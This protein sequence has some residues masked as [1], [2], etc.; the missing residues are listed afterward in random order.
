MS[1]SIEDIKAV[2]KGIT[3][4]NDKK[5]YNNILK[6]L[7]QYSQVTDDEGEFEK[8]EPTMRYLTVALFQIFK[9]LFT[10]G[11]LNPSKAANDQENLFFGWCRKNYESFKA[12]LLHFISTLSF[13]NSLVLDSLDV[14]F[15][16]IELESVYYASKEGAPFFPNK[17]LKKLILALFQST[18]DNDVDPT[19]GESIN[20][21]VRE[22]SEKY[23]KKYVDIQ[24]YFQ[25]E[26]SQVCNDESVSL[27][28]IPHEELMSKWLTIM[29]HDNHYSSKDADLDIFVPQPPTAMENEA[30]FKSNFEKN[31]I[32]FLSLSQLTTPQYKTTLL[33]LHKRVIQHF[34]TP[35]KLMDFLTDS[36]NVGG[37][38]SILSLNGLFELMRRY[39][40]EYPNFYTKLY[41]LIDENLMHVKYR[42]RFLRLTDTFLSST[43]LSAN[44]I[45]SFIKKL[46]RLT[47]AA[48]PAA[49]VSV[50]PFVYNLLKKHPNCMIMLHDPDYIADPFATAEQNEKLKLY[51][52]QYTDPFDFEEPN[53]ELSCALGS[54]LWELESLTSHYH[55]NVATLAKIFG[56]PFKKLSYN[57]ED[58]L[59][60][61]YD[62][63]IAAEA[64]RKL[65]VLPA[66]EFEDT[67]ALFGGYL[68]NVE[69]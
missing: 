19:S 43:H 21:V 3:S 59:D 52:Q 30:K 63:L 64:S 51:K 48:P 29:N 28:A 16:C 9:K 4:K 50:I 25:S 56:Q 1:L 17:T 57:V 65:K 7:N 24:F 66:L 62:S 20:V 14:Y 46:A 27:A 12:K 53:P 67:G 33:I 36:Y 38:V 22:F 42:S 18:I 32:W 31:W 26:L 61:S 68:E 69:W 55:P 49:I 35:T 60:W 54:S 13:E 2:S 5:Q 23:Y 10:R 15:Q 39:N 47:L 58:F 8:V 44:L 37:V 34:Q 45:A 41:Q 6:L 11:Q 40:L